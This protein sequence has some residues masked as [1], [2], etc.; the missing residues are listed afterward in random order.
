MSLCK[1]AISIHARRFSSFVKMTR[2][3]KD[4]S[5]AAASTLSRES[6]EKPLVDLFS[7]WPNPSLL[8]PLQLDNAAH[9]VLNDRGI[10]AESLKYAADEGY[11]PLREEIAKSLTKFYAPRDPITAD[12]I[13]ISGGASQNLACV[14]QTFT[15][16]V[17]TRNVWMVAPTYFLACRIFDDSG[18]GGRLR[19]VPEDADGLDIEYLKKKIEL[20]EQN[21]INQGNT[22]PKMKTRYPWRRTYKHV[23]YAVPT[24]ANP[25]GRLMSQQRREQLVRMAREYDALIVTDDVYDLLQWSSDPSRRDA[26]PKKAVLPRIVDVDRYLDGGPVSEW[27]NALSSGSFSK[28]VAP[29]C[30]TGWAEGTP[31]TAWALSQTGSSRSGGAPSGLVASMLYQMMAAGKFEQHVSEVLLPAYEKR[32]NE[33]MRAV[34]DEL[35]PLGV[36]VP[37]PNKDVAGGYFVWLKLP[38]SLDATAITKEAM[39]KENLKTIAGPKFRVQ[40]DEDKDEMQFNHDIRLCFSYEE[41]DKLR[42]GVIRL[43]KVIKSNLAK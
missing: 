33:M 6:T 12:R 40:G 26:P 13:C 34:R 41:F 18:F 10:A 9:V 25:S 23:I 36:T 31:K 14:L 43:A 37:Q 15:D 30:R 4:P 16:P 11:P 20:S 2:V 39:E 5:K 28:I 17:Y 7:G 22:E 27:G 35:I 29:G 8:P 3:V 19:G 42:E 24:F 21:A 38:G 1:L 32:Y